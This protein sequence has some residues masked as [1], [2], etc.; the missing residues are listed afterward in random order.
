[1][2]EEIRCQTARIPLTQPPP[3]ATATVTATG[4][5]AGSTHGVVLSS[6]AVALFVMVHSTLRGRWSDNGV[7]V[8]PGEPTTLGFMPWGAAPGGAKAFGASLHVDVANAGSVV[9]V[10]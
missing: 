2:D 5:P 10:Q 9:S 7:L 3:I 1:M 6:D 4:L 8:L